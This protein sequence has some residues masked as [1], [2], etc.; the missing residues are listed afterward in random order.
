M[1]AAFLFFFSFNIPFIALKR[2]IDGLLFGS[3]HRALGSRRLSDE[4]ETNGC[5]RRVLS[6][7]TPAWFQ[8]AGK[9]PWIHQRRH[10]SQQSTTEKKSQRQYYHRKTPSVLADQ[11]QNRPKQKF[12]LAFDWPPS[13]TL[14]RTWAANAEKERQKETE[15]TVD[16]M[17]AVFQNI[18]PLD[19]R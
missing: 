13:R 6:H 4:G 11:Q 15:R 5:S 19:I 1:W 3:E 7:C 12:R 16:E 18:S 9:E 17:R 8:S 14:E 10:E 2:Y